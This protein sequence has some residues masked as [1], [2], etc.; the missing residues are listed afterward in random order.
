MYREGAGVVAVV[1][2]NEQNIENATVRASMDGTI[3]LAVD[4]VEYM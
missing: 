3:N 1:I 2:F 4:L